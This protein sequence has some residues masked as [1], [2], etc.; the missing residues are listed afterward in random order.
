MGNAARRKTMLVIMDGWGLS[1]VTDGNATYLAK[2]PTLDHIYGNYPKISITASGVEVGLTRGEM[3]NSEVGHLN[4][5]TG[6]VVWES[7]P[8]IDRAIETG[9]FEKSAELINILDKAKSGKLHLIGIT[10]TGGVHSHINHLYAILDVAKKRGVKDACIHFVSD[11]RDTSPKAALGTAEQL[12]TKIEQIGLGRVSTLVGRYFAMDRDSRWQRT[13]K[14]YRLMTEGKGK[15]TNSLTEAIEQSYKDQVFD[16]FI[17]P[18]VIDKTGLIEHG[19]TIIF[20]N[21]RV[22]RVRELL[23]A[24]CSFDFNG[25]RRNKIT[26]LSI[27][28]MTEYDARYGLP[29]MFK[30]TNLKNTFADSISSAG[31][32]QFHTAE[33]EK[34][35]HVTYFF[36]GGVEK[37]H[38]AEK[39]VIVPSPKVPTYDKK[40]EMSAF[41]LSEKVISAIIAEED[42][43]LVNFA[44]GDMVGHTGIL[45][46]SVKA[47]EA[48]DQCLEKVM[49]AASGKGYYVFLTAD[50]GNC[51]NMIDPVTGEPDKEH[52]TNPVPFVAMD[53]I[54]KPFV[55]GAETLFTRE[56]LIE[57]SSEGPA[58]IL[59]DVASTI[60]S[61]MG[62]EKPEEMIGTD[63][64][65][66]MD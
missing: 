40:P 28:T 5:G 42:F 10:S 32:T 21:F 2:T 38:V 37:P 58:G 55:S 14:A 8:R 43:I 11:G 66:L 56:D 24:F 18:V 63:L 33:T 46:A 7:L 62:V 31:L 19:D 65:K 57:Y 41:E 17:E 30:P 54:S 59:A 50:H 4:L 48:V 25:F 44:N 29:V 61:V 16:E 20:Y 36:N 60:L 15:E 51:E 35:P 3:G 45:D 1:P 34:Y 27:A 47:C 23:E 22:D 26:P 39:D 9:E 52:T 49:L 12:L 53:F 13:E 6:R 64:T